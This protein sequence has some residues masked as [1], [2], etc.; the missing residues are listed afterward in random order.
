MKGPSEVKLSLTLSPSIL[1]S[2]LKE[3]IKA[4]TDIETERQRLIY[5]GKV[6][7]DEEPLSLY[8]VQVSHFPPQL[9]EG[10]LR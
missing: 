4:Q 7:K 3:K 6:L 2:E 9:L 10:T 8:K 1:V 5:S